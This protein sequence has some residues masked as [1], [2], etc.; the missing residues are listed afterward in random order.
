MYSF[1]PSRV[2]ATSGISCYA[3]TFVALCTATVGVLI[4]TRGDI[5]KEGGAGAVDA[6]YHRFPETPLQHFYN[7]VS[8]E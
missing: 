2:S 8:F 1:S 5:E 3:L 6:L 4:K 7:T